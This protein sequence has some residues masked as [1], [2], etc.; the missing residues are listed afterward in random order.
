MDK[1]FKLK[2]IKCTTH[3]LKQI[4]FDKSYINKGIEKHCFFSIKIYKLSCAQANIIKQTALSCGTDCA[5]HKEVITGNIEF[6]DCI[7]S[8][9]KNE[10]FKIAEKLKHQ[11]FK[12]THL[13]DQIIKTVEPQKQTTNIR[14]K[15]FDWNDK[16]YLMGILNITP[17]SFSDGGKYNTISNA[18]EH[19]KHLILTGADII[20]IG[21]EST[22]PFS[23]SISVDEEIK[24]V[25]PVIEEIR[26]FDIETPISID[27]RNA[28]TANEALSAGADIINDV[29]GLEW[30]KKMI[31]IIKQH[32]CPIILGHIQGTPETMQIN[33][34]YEDVVEELYDYFL[35][36]TQYLINLG[37]EPGKIIIDPC[38]G[39][40]KTTEQNF[41]IINRLEE[42]K[43]LNFPILIGHSRKTFLQQAINTQDNQSLDEVTAIVTQRLLEKKVNII[44]VHNTKINQ[45]ALKI[46]NNL[47]I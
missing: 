7:L 20:D 29:S 44:R 18:I 42:L 19:Y 24:R 23:K 35:T 4:G 25:I 45:Y 10:F 34:Q 31:N 43:S 5:V 21:G 28:K 26:K 3:K 11:P 8:G 37:I 22:K 16:A 9:T 32:N 17:N 36:K 40:G 39:F 12:L 30:D 2:Q 1:T 38:L 13:A 6:S 14:E 27:T 15:N 47:L 41:E 46:N 33:P